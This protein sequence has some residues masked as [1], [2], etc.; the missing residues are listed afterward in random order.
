MTSPENTS[1]V[2]LPEAAFHA[3]TTQEL[4]ECLLLHLAHLSPGVTA[5]WLAVME[6]GS[7]ASHPVAAVRRRTKLG[8]TQMV[9]VQ[10]R[11]LE[12]AKHR[13]LTRACLEDVVQ[14]E[15]S[16]KTAW[17]ALP[18]RARA[19]RVGALLLRY[20]AGLE[21]DARMQERLR[22]AALGAATLMRERK[23]ETLFREL[24]QSKQHW[25]AAFDS[26]PDLLTIHDTNGR[27]LK[28]NR[29]LAQRLGV[30]AQEV[31]RDASLFARHFPL[32]CT[33]TSPSSCLWHSDTL[34]ATF[35]LTRTPIYNR[36]QEQIGCVHHLRD[37]TDQLRLEGQ[38]RQQ[39]RLAALGE[40]MSGIAHELNNPLAGIIGYAERLRELAAP[41]QFSGR[42]GNYL[43]KIGLEAERAAHI[44]RS[45]LSFAR[46]Q[47][48]KP[49]PLSL[50]AVAWESAE[51]L[52]DSLQAE[53]VALALELYDPA[54][55]IHGDFHALQQVLINLI[56]NARQ[57]IREVR[58]HGRITLTTA[59]T[60]EGGALLRVTDDGPGI[61]PEH[62]ARLL[63]PFFTTKRVGEGTGLGLSICYGILQAHG[64]ELK[65]ESEAGQGASFTMLFPP[66]PLEVAQNRMAQTGNS[67]SD[68]KAVSDSVLRIV[69]LDDEETVRELVTET[70][71]DDGHEV[72]AFDSPVKALEALSLQRFDLI[73][74]DVRMPEMDGMEF[75]DRICAL[76]PELAARLLFLTGDVLAPGLDAFFQRTG[77]HY[78]NKPFGLSTLRAA[79]AA[80]TEP[81]TAG[82][83]TSQ[84]V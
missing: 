73:L 77:C 3:E 47:P 57:A 52:Q 82:T 65:I 80:L 26:L 76:R 64:A 63:D 1:D 6:E 24:E 50:N 9:P 48:A 12:P 27:L 34:D 62:R 61:R 55:D 4:G 37:I 49:V 53:G 42:A 74:S 69:V 75:Y 83:E 31:V 56:T 35:A 46:P 16:G 44:V 54:P 72:V 7:P 41:E 22:S 8:I 78:L 38:A 13:R 20:D 10:T 71:T 14:I 2:L 43:R 79:I 66:L 45:L 32:D 5:G 17:V 81:E 15:H 33:P 67:L 40:T 70:L 19:E 21:P 68:A 36:E 18:L 39:E 30:A 28:V 60:P 29:A 51:L 11:P 25:E 23:R 59:P 84:G 58:A